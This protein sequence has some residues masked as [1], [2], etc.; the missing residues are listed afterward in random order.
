M[1]PEGGDNSHLSVHSEGKYPTW[2]DQSLVS[3]ECLLDA[4]CMQDKSSIPGSLW[5]HSTA[6]SKT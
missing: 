5:A 6:Q 4:G 2:R 1:G 3:A